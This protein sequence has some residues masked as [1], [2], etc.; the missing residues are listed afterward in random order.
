MNSGS[1]FRIHVI[2]DGVVYS[3]SPPKSVSHIVGVGVQDLDDIIVVWNENVDF[4][5]RNA[6]TAQGIPGSALFSIMSGRSI[7]NITTAILERTDL[8]TK[9]RAIGLSTSDLE[10]LLTRSVE[11]VVIDTQTLRPEDSEDTLP[12]PYQD[13][14][15]PG[16]VSRAL[17]AEIVMYPTVGERTVYGSAIYVAP[18]SILVRSLDHGKTF[19]GA[20]MVRRTSDKI[21]SDEIIGQAALAAHDTQITQ[22]SA[23]FEAW[24]PGADHF[25]EHGALAEET[26]AFFGIGAECGTNTNSGEGF[27]FWDAVLSPK[28]QAA[29]DNLA[30][31]WKD[32]TANANF[33]GDLLGG[34][35]VSFLKLSCESIA[36]GCQ[37]NNVLSDKGAEGGPYDQD[38]GTG[39]ALDDLSDVLKTTE[40]LMEAFQNI[41]PDLAVTTI[42]LG[43]LSKLRTEPCES[44]ANVGLFNGLESAN[45]GTL[46]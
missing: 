26:M 44:P 22:I 15:Y 31:E 14:P 36:L 11:K 27:N 24:Q 28:Q 25:I 35:G 13:I 20:D 33:T 9:L 42:G 29:I 5:Q 10:L 18:I 32:I 17:N 34:L 2:H 19:G 39:M 43:N 38:G 3:N 12:G 8:I 4:K 6:I 40:R 41:G 21:G 7:D 45:N 30:S 46:G 37:G 1:K 23:S 16:E